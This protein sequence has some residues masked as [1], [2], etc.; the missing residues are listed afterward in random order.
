[1]S[2]YASHIGRMSMVRRSFIFA[3]LA[4]LILMALH[5]AKADAAPAEEI[6]YTFDIGSVPVSRS[7]DKVAVVDVSATLLY[8][9]GVASSDYPDIRPIVDDI[10]KFVRTYPEKKAYFEVLAKEASARILASQPAVAA[11]VVILTIHTDE[12]RS[13]KRS[14]RAALSR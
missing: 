7:D 6:S 14:V 1:M 9:A 11:V 5:P 4:G 8:T 12:T 13:Y 10:N 2:V 3:T